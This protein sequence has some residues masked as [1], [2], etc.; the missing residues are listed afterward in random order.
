M[1]EPNDFPDFYK[2]TNKII[3]GDKTLVDLPIMRY[4]TLQTFDDISNAQFFVHK[5]ET[6]PDL[7]E[8]GK[9]QNDKKLFGLFSIAGEKIPQSIMEDYNNTDRKIKYSHHLFTSCW[10]TS[11]KEDI[12]MWKAYDADILI[13]TTVREFLDSINT[14]NIRLI[15]CNKIQYNEETWKS[16]DLSKEIFYKVPAYINEK[17]IRFYI[18]FKENII[19]NFSYLTLKQGFINTV[20]F[21]PFKFNNSVESIIQ[22]YQIPNDRINISEIIEKC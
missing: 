10:T 7:R 17:E 9:Y 15:V 18:D 14:D 19:E 16:S 12:L 6:F 3:I 20:T 21:S 5:R 11:I 8:Q 22:A 4:T 13:R 2:Y 1:I